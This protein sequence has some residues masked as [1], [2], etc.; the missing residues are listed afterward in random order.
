MKMLIRLKKHLVYYN[1]EVFAPEGMVVKAKMA[2]SEEIEIRS[3]EVNPEKLVYPQSSV[4]LTFGGLSTTLNLTVSSQRHPAFA[5]SGYIINDDFS[6]KKD[7]D[8]WLVFDEDTDSEDFATVGIEN[9]AIKIV[10]DA[11]S[12]LT[13]KIYFNEN[14][15]AITKPTAISF[16]VSRID[17]AELVMSTNSSQVF[18]FWYKDGSVRPRRYSGGVGQNVTAGSVGTYAG[19]I[20][21]TYLIDPVEDKYSMW[22]NGTKEV[23]DSY[24]AKTTDITYMSVKFNKTIVSG[25]STETF[26][27]DNVKVWE[28]A[29]EEA[30]C[31]GEGY[32]NGNLQ[33]GKIALSLPISYIPNG[34]DNKVTV[35]MA[36]YDK[37]TNELIAI[38]DIEEHTFTGAEFHTFTPE[39]TIPDSAGDYYVKTMVWKSGTFAPI[40]AATVI[41]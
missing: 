8:A 9:E 36:A 24:L 38:S 41:E 12:K 34:T 26:T 13:A 14:K 33:T 5:A 3:Y 39:M 7:R 1:G 17:A 28:F 4:T 30:T 6:E 19:P 27:V 15:T 40:C 32:N 10:R 16:T 18:A 22:V 20:T 31:S 35:I 23:T 25:R 11:D 29:K 37:V 21:V 2:N